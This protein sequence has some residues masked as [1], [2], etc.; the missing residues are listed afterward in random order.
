MKKRVLSF[1]LSVIFILSVFPPIA[2]A[3]TVDSKPTEPTRQNSTVEAA[4]ETVPEVV[5]ET[6]AEPTDAVP[7]VHDEPIAPIAQAPT[8]LQPEPATEPTEAEPYPH[9]S[10]PKL[11]GIENVASGQKISWEA[12][13]GAP[14][15]RVYVKN[16]SLWKKLADTTSTTYINTKVAN[17]RFY[18]YTVRCLN[19]ARDYPLSDRD[20]NGIS[21]TFFAAPKITG[22]TPGNAGVT[23]HWNAVKSAYRYAF[24]VKKAGKWVKLGSTAKT[25]YT[26]SDLTDGTLYEFTVRC[27]NKNGKFCSG[28]Y[29]DAG[30]YRYIAPI[31]IT[32]V[33]ADN[34]KPV[35]TWTANPDVVCYRVE[36]KA[37][38]GKWSVVADVQS[39]TF[40]DQSAKAN[41]P[42]TYSVSALD[43]SGNKLSA[44]F[45]NNTFYAN[46]APA[47]G[48]FKVDGTTFSFSGGKLVP[49]YY[50]VN[51]RQYYFNADT[52]FQ[53]NG[54]VGSKKHGYTYADKY[55]VCCTSK[56]IRLAADYLMT[57]CTG[58]TNAEKMKSGFAYMAKNYPYQRIYFDSP[59][60]H[61]VGS[62]AVELFTT[63]RGTCYRYA[64]GFACLAR[65]CGYRV[66]FVNG[67]VAEYAP[68]GWTEVYYNGK[69]R[70]CDPDYQLPSY[71][72]P[73]YH[74]YMMDEH[75]WDIRAYWKSE[76]VIKNGKAVWQ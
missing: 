3:E 75:D 27:L 19:E 52:T 39:A 67:I 66:R 76:L 57:H 65:L 46:G 72:K 12:V 17:V 63:K 18:T 48:K 1:V 45:Y 22:Y 40:T 35:L 11:T 37:F 53:K 6:V 70:I 8:E 28:F 2:A 55:G 32:K 51:K 34:K 5:S 25:S 50:T 30:S 7:T 44:N 9:L 33:T 43:C 38:R 59:R 29:P 62:Y 21:A 23:V 15:Y 73:A 68:H 47:K 10:T 14:V 74:A 20:E 42:Y 26:Y 56:E 64:A 36:R 71:H 69:W 60:S 41:T 54:I 49:G 58:K 13:E 31:K 61:N 24:F 16:G 4:A